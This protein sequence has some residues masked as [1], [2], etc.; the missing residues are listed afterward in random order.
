[1]AWL[2]DFDP[3][4]TTSLSLARSPGCHPVAASDPPTD[5]AEVHPQESPEPLAGQEQEEAH[6]EEGVVRQLQR[7]LLVELRDQ[8]GHVVITSCHPILSSQNVR[9]CACRRRPL[10][11]VCWWPCARLN[12]DTGLFPDGSKPDAS[13]LEQNRSIME[14]TAGEDAEE[15]SA[16]EPEPEPA[17]EEII[18]GGSDG[19]AQE[20]RNKQLMLLFIVIA[21][22]CAHFGLGIDDLEAFARNLIGNSTNGSA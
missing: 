9:I 16:Q 3:Q 7:V 21:V 12:P 2:P 20:Q 18:E 1:M 8:A 6:L 11:M 10:I 14:R 17:H 4:C 22:V 19:D 13:E 15:E 5:G